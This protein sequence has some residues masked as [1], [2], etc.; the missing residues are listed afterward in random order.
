MPVTISE[1]E[2]NENLCLAF[3]LMLE[4]LGDRSIAIVFF[5]TDREPFTDIYRTTWKELEIQHWV[6]SLEVDGLSCYRLTGFGWLEGLYQVGQ[7]KQDAIKKM[8]GGYAATLKHYVKGRQQDRIIL[9]NTLVKEA[10]LPEGFVFNAIESG[11]LQKSSGIY[12]ATWVDRGLLVRIP[13]NFGVKTV[14]HT[15]DIRAQL[16]SVQEELERAKERLSEVTCSFCG[17]PIVGQGSIPISDHVDGYFVAYEC[18]RYDTDSGSSQPCSLDPN[19]PKLEDYELIFQ[20]YPEESS[21]KWTCWAKPRSLNARRL[22]L[23]AEYGRK[24]RKPNSEWWNDTIGLQN[25][26]RDSSTKG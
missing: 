10:G 1:R 15:A 13:L 18:G 8:M 16:E 6:E 25:P 11:L 20:E 19:F 7:F 9:F 14:D 2:Q 17:A 4:E 24:K 3:R 21:T 5:R 12:D 22:D 26:G 23:H